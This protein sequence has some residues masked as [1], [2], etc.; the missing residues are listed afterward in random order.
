MAKR[1][2]VHRTIVVVDIAESTHPIRTNDDRLVIREAMYDALSA[3]FGRSVVS[4]RHDW[5]RCRWEDRGDGVLILVPPEVPKARLVTGL[6]ERLEGAL[7]VSQRS[8]GR[9]RWRAGRGHAGTVAGR[10]ARRG[11]HVR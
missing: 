10:G 8:H 3:A 1:D 11:G 5:Q 6:P 9:A 4:R 2:A 7:R